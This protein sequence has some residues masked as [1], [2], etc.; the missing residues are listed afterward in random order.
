MTE[1]TEE[2]LEKLRA[3]LGALKVVASDSG[4]PSANYVSVRNINVVFDKH[5]LALRSKC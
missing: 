5:V 3:E 1:L 4:Y 2:Y